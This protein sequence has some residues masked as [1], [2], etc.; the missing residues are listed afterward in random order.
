MKLNFANTIEQQKLWHMDVCVFCMWRDKKLLRGTCDGNISSNRLTRTTSLFSQTVQMDDNFCDT[1]NQACRGMHTHTNTQSWSSGGGEQFWS[2]S[3]CAFVLLSFFAFSLWGWTMRCL[4]CATIFDSSCEKVQPSFSVVQIACC[5][6]SVHWKSEMALIQWNANDV[7]NHTS[8]EPL[9]SFFTQH[10]S[11]FQQ[12]ACGKLGLACRATTPKQMSF[13]AETS[14]PFLKSIHQTPTLCSRDDI[15]V[16]VHASAITTSIMVALSE[17]TNCSQQNVKA[18][19]SCEMCAIESFC[20]MIHL[21]SISGQKFHMKCVTKVKNKEPWWLCEQAFWLKW[22]MILHHPFAK[23]LKR[24]AGWM[25]VDSFCALVW[26]QVNAKKEELTWTTGPFAVPIWLI[27]CQRPTCPRHVNFTPFHEFK[28]QQRRTLVRTRN[29]FDIHVVMNCW[30]NKDNCTVVL[31]CS[32][33][34]TNITSR[35]L[36]CSR[37]RTLLYEYSNSMNGFYNST[38]KYSTDTSLLVTEGPY[39]ILELTGTSRYIT[40]LCVHRHSTVQLSTTQYG[41]FHHHA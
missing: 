39:S 37:L 3:F 31:P 26:P 33:A 19:V 13:F 35:R 29:T 11:W 7:T 24:S 36:S 23:C 9:V 17:M 25:K 1:N 5:F 12:C 15:V 22:A 14:N 8:G 27:V 20:R 32:T 28:H 30:T 38:V 6:S 10:K 21:L 41:K 16:L 2:S 40:V 34:V 4:A 18:C